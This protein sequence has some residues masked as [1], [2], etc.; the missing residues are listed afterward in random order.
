MIQFQ[1]HWLSPDS[2]KEKNAH[3]KLKKLLERH[4]NDPVPANL[5]S[6]LECDIDS[7]WL[8]MHCPVDMK[9]DE[10]GEMLFK[11]QWKPHWIP[12]SD[13]GSKADAVEDALGSL[14]AGQDL[15]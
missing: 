9:R 11:I 4:R 7:L 1:E 13:V 14:G 5:G 10:K 2:F 15:V 6:K 8:Q 12:Q 3:S